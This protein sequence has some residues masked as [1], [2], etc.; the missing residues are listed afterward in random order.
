QPQMPP[1]LRHRNR[2]SGRLILLAAC[3]GLA[4][5]ARAADYVVQATVTDID[6][7]PLAGVQVGVGPIK[8]EPFKTAV[9]AEQIGATDA[10]GQVT[11]KIDT[12]S[13]PVG[14]TVIGEDPGR[15]HL[16][17]DTGIARLAK[18]ANKVP[19]QLLPQP[20]S[21]RMAAG[22]TGATRGFFGATGK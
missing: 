1:A 9:S 4:T 8:S 16:P 2:G 3:L 21:T 6:G 15:I 5:A 17:A 12:S 14:A 18:G 20:D 19:F 11:V 13:S 10:A 22:G 7:R